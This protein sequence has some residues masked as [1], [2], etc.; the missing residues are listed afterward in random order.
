MFTLFPIVMLFTSPLTTALN[1]TLHSL[2]ITTSPTI[3]A[4][5][6]IKQSSGICG[7]TPFTGSITGMAMVLLLFKDIVLNHAVN[8]TESIFHSYFLP[9]LISTAIIRYANFIY[10]YL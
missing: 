10:T 2:P 3:V 6:A 9:F 7:D 4:L 5:G 1:Q 8:S